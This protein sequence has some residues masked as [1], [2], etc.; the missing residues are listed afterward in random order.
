MASKN[1]DLGQDVMSQTH[2]TAKQVFGLNRQ[3]SSPKLSSEENEPSSGKINVKRTAVHTVSSLLSG[4]VAG[5]VAKTCIAPLDRTKISFQGTT[6]HRGFSA[7]FQ[8]MLCNSIICQLST[9][10]PLT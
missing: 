10:E 8:T 9:R 3:P 2:S 6:L 7:Q 4:A 5:A 1:T